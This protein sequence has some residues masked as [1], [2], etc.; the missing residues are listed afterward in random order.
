MQQHSIGW[1]PSTI[2]DGALVGGFP[3]KGLWP[4]TI[5]QWDCIT[6][7]NGGLAS[8]SC[9]EKN[10]LSFFTSHLG[11]VL[12]V[13]LSRISNLPLPCSIWETDAYFPLVVVV[14]DILQERNL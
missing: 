8:N 3:C 4:D 14:I 10:K 2:T 6:L 1:V 7:L 9:F 12:P 13:L 11:L 5:D